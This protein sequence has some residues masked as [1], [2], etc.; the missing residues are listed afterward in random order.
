[1]TQLITHTP[2]GR[3]NPASLLLLAC[4]ALAL[5]ACGTTRHYDRV[6]PTGAGDY[7][8][9]KPYKVGG[10]WYKPQEDPFYD[11]VG[12]ASWYGRDFH[13]RSTAN[14]ERFDMNK[15]T[16][17][18]TTLPMPS[19]VRVTN[20]SNGRSLVLRVNDRGPF[21]KGRIIDVSRRAAQLLGFEKKGVERVRV[22]A[23]SADGRILG[24]PGRKPR[25][26]AAAP[27]ARPSLAAGSTNP[28]PAAAGP[29]FVQIGSFQSSDNAMQ[30]V[31]RLKGLG[32]VLIQSAVVN[33]Q[34]VFRLRIGP[35]TSSERALETLRKVRKRGFYEARIF[36]APVS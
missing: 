15:L 21:A 5:S 11:R 20:L 10:V 16:A 18:H 29:V 24:K 32:P 28:N 22:Q 26:T 30:L 36:T 25:R 7:K 14:G 8:V 13:G 35:F 17:A 31:P 12:N 4:L 1:M 33:D 23:V 27:P 3:R 2:A 6:A 34:A 19:H 9:G